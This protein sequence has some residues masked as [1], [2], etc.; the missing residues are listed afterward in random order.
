MGFLYISKYDFEFQ[1]INPIIHDFGESSS[2]L[3][4]KEVH[5][6]LMPKNEF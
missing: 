3:R 5:L 2:R 6:H 1:A 4:K